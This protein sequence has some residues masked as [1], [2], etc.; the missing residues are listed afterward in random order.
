MKKLDSA[1]FGMIPSEVRYNKEL[2]PSHKLLYAEITACLGGDGVCT[3]SNLYFSKVLN[4]SKGT[5]SN[6]LNTLRKLG[7]I[8]VTIE[9]EEGTMKF[10][11]R[12]IVPTYT[13]GRVGVEESNENT[14]TSDNVGVSDSSP[15]RDAQNSTS[16]NGTLLYNNNNINTIYKK[17][18]AMDTPLNKNI[19]DEQKNALYKIVHNFYTV[20]K[21]IYPDMIKNEDV[22]GSI[23]VLYDLIRIDGY[24]YES[25]RDSIQWAIEDPFWGSNLFSLK[26]LRNK[27]SNGLSK[28]QNLH[29]RYKSQ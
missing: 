23:N 4:M 22:N 13:S 15:L 26:T 8:N 14:H 27:S 5:V 10:L 2:K 17:H 12:Y 3:R 1:Y 11:N 18:Q 29:H 9:N 6:Y 25:V 7:F 16:R 28:F 19:N 21:S 20:Q 24:Q